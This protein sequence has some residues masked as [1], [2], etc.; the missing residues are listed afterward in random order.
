[1]ACSVGLIAGVA[2]AIAPA[3]TAARLPVLVALSGRRPATTSARRTLLLGMTLIATSIGLTATGTAW[4][5]TNRSDSVAPLLLGV[6]AI[7]GVLGF[8]A[9][10]PW[11]VEHLEWLGSRLP[12]AGRIALRDTARARSR[13]APIVTAVLAGL[14]AAIAISTAVAST[15]DQFG[16]GP[17]MRPDQLIVSGQEALDLGPEVAGRLS[18][19][20]AAEVPQPGFIS[21]DGSERSLEVQITQNGEAPHLEPS[22]PCSDCRD[23]YG[24]SVATPDLLAALGVPPDAREIAPDSVLLLVNGPFNA[25]A[26]TM[27][28]SEWE[29]QQMGTD[30]ST[31]VQRY[32]HVETLPARAVDVGAAANGRF[33]TMF[34]APE[35]AARLG[36]RPYDLEADNDYLI[37]L[38]RPVAEGDLE[39][40]A[41]L[42]VDS[43]FTFA[44]ASLPR[45]NPTDLARLI[46]TFLSVALALTITAIAVALGES[47]SRGDQRAL[48]AIGA[49]PALRRRIVAARA[50]VIA[51]LAAL[52]AVPAGLLPVWGLLASRDK[53][54]VI[55]LPELLAILVLLPVVAIVGSLLLSRPIPGW[56]AFREVSSG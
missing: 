13:T 26:A 28:V 39:F 37:R 9:W 29:E 54:V 46:V 27:A 17:W 49:D 6:G 3:W 31:I 19:I 25:H 2:A 51:L 43:R 41:S 12:L 15:R 40:A 56:S 20:A 38:D 52:L 21:I 50:G 48:L 16:G 36:F 34:I 30:D 23:F 1:M 7:A 10:S 24:P 11:L 35:T 44:D 33:A 8:G 22:N 18:A 45:A 47:E 5:L 4:L 32:T 53:P 14:A 42:L 55:P